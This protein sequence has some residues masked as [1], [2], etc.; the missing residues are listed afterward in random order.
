MNEKIKT[1]L[2]ARERKIYKLLYINNL[3]P[4]ECAKHL[5]NEDLK[6]YQPESY[7]KILEFQ[8]KVISLSKQ[9]IYDED[10]CN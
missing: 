7:A 1:K 10:I 4:T 8:R 6:L 3:T 9:I 2:S 5:K